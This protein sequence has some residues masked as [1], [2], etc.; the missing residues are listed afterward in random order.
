M[1]PIAALQGIA[2]VSGLQ[3]VNS[4]T[5][6]IRAAQAAMAAEPVPVHVARERPARV[7]VDQGPLVLVETRKDLSQ[8]KLPFETGAPTAAQP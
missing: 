7:V 4:D 2:E 5:D 1:L 3:W 8:L 6:K